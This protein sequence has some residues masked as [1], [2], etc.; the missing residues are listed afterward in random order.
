[1]PANRP[2][3]VS[4]SVESVVVVGVSE[5]PVV[6]VAAHV[7]PLIVLLSRVTVPASRANTRPS[8]V[9]P[10]FRA[11]VPFRARIFPI[12]DVVV[13]RVAELPI[14]H[15]TLHGSPPVTDEP[16]DVIMVDTVLNI[17]TPDPVRFRLP[18]SVKLLVEQ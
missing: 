12:K 4:L 16:G 10:L 3:D 7:G 13:S 9:A 2:P 17:Q 15:H 11:V 5:S 1:M 18:L 8:N 14:L 6:S